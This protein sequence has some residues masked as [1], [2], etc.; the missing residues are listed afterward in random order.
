MK[1][2]R[3]PSAESAA[4]VDCSTAPDLTLV[5][6]RNRLTNESKVVSKPVSNGM[7]NYGD[8]RT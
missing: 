6:R 7:S 3:E 2:R 5:Q 8:V 4:E 1:E